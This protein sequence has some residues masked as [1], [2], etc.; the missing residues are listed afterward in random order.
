M[1]DTIAIMLDQHQFEI[2]D[3]GRFSPDSRNLFEPPYYPF[4]NGRVVCVQNPSSA[5]RQAGIYRPRLTLTKRIVRAGI[6]SITLKIEFS[7]PKL[8][9]G[10]NFIEVSDRDFVEIIGLLDASL[11]DMGVVIADPYT[12]LPNAP[13][14]AVHYSKNVVLTDGVTCSMVLHELSKADMTRVLDANATDYR[15]GGHALRL[16]A[17]SYEVIWYDK[18]KDLQK[19]RT[20]EKRALEKDS[21]CQLDIFADRPKTSPLPEIFRMEVRL[22]NRKKIRDM[23]A[24]LNHPGEPLFKNL[25]N[26]ALAQNVLLHFWQK[27]CDAVLLVSISLKS[28]TKAFHALR[29]D[30]PRMKPNKALQVLAALA[31]IQEEGAQ[32]FRNSYCLHG[33]DKAWSRLKTDLNGFD[34]NDLRGFIASGQ[35]TDGLNRFERCKDF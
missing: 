30:N 24:R 33:N 21:H 25:F 18:G 31:L 19:A 35:I 22:G 32:A 28:L 15:N 6:F 27:T 4:Q 14:S 17:N 20:S 2:A 1:I 5:D 10:N 12:T 29:K 11:K 16:H 26:A 34:L 9:H 23:M 7:I 8:F 3:H 13:A